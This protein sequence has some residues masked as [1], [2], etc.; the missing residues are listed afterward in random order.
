MKTKY[1]YIYFEQQTEFDALTDNP[2][3]LCK[4]NRLKTILAQIYY[5]DVWKQYVAEFSQHSV[6]SSDCLDD[7]SDFLKQLNKKE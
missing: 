6:Y 5:Y 4:T 3:Y 7:I 2:V 1:K